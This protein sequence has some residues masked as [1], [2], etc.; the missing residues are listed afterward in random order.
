MFTLGKGAT[1]SYS[2]KV[3][4]NTR[5]STETEL[6]T[7]DMYMP[8]MLWSL[9][10]IQNQGYKPE[11]VGLYQDNISTQLLIKNGKFSS[12][13]KTKH[14][15]AK[16]FFIKDWVDNGEIKVIDCPAEELWAD[17]L[18]KPL[19]GMAFQTMRAQLMNCPIN[20]EDPSNEPTKQLTRKP[21]VAKQSV[22]WGGTKQV[23]SWTL[24]ECVGQNRSNRPSHTADRQLGIARNP[25]RLGKGGRQ[26]TTRKQ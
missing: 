17:I 19:Q 7:A 13:K 5:S 26:Q 12:G 20:Y 16:F 14:V 4:L 25:A 6:V 9:Y 24:Q 2:R 11:C 22:T 3:K 15:K 23:P 18:T 1:N 10:F 8:E 21:V